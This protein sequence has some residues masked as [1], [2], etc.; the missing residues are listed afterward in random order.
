[1]KICYTRD[2]VPGRREGCQNKD[3][4]E[5]NNQ[6]AVKTLGD[7]FSTYIVKAGPSVIIRTV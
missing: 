7:S 4:R 5:L 3:P 1:M 2:S 6:S